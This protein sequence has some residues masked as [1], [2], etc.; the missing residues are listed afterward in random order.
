VARRCWPGGGGPWVAGWR[1]SGGLALVLA[2][3]WWPVTGQGGWSR[4]RR[5]WARRQRQWPGERHGG[6]GGVGKRQGGGGGSVCGKEVAAV[7][8]NGLGGRDRKTK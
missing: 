4:R 6:G 2:G 3:R 1:R 7:S 5:D 8:E